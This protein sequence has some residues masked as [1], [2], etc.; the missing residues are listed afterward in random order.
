MN[1][2]LGL[3]LSALFSSVYT[4]QCLQCTGD[5]GQCTTTN[6]LECPAGSMCSAERT[7]F[8]AS[9]PNNTLNG[10]KCAAC[11]GQANTT[12]NSTVFC[13]GNQV[14]C[15]TSIVSNTTVKGCISKS[16]CGVSTYSNA[17]C[18]SGNMCNGSEAWLRLDLS[19]LLM[20]LLAV[21]LLQ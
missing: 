12:C 13:V 1:L 8:S 5:S 17:T 18:C 20:V 3:H 6:S 4:L 15:V 2:L 10:L 21:I 14:Q 16:L 11:S 9:E 19:H 7:Y